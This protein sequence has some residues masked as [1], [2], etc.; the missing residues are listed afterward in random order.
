MNL[1]E[2]A[3]LVRTAVVEINVLLFYGSKDIHAAGIGRFICALQVRTPCRFHALN[4]MFCRQ[5]YQYC[6]LEFYR[7]N[8]CPQECTGCIWAMMRHNMHRK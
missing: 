6:R 4:P 8:K 5:H 7:T 2:V 3:E 1:E